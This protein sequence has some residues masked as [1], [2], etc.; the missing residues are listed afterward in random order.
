MSSSAN[1]AHHCGGDG[2]RHLSTPSWSLLVVPP[3]ILSGWPFL[4]ANPH[5]KAL[6]TAAA[7]PA[8]FDYIINRADWLADLLI[9]HQG[10]TCDSACVCLCMWY[11]PAHIMKEIKHDRSDCKQELWGSI[12][13]VCIND[14]KI[15]REW[16]QSNHTHPCIYTHFSLQPECCDTSWPYRAAV[17]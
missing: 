5:Q 1:P 10:V 15:N 9:R 7:P 17:V 11:T 2:P 14:R 4:S 8:S 13:S 3:L 12:W 16:L 6:I